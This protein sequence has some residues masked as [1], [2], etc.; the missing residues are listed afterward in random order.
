VEWLIL[1][2][3][4]NMSERQLKN[5]TDMWAGNKTFANFNGNNRIIQNLNGRKIN[6]KGML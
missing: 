5:F 1:P 4:V 2:E 6:T 3:P